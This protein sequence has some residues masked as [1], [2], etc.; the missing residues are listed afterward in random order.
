[1]SQYT[2]F[3]WLIVNGCVR[4]FG[5]GAIV[6]GVVF[7]AW[8]SWLLLHRDATIGVNGVPSNDPWDKATILIAGLVVLVLGILVL[9]AR[10]YRPDLGDSASSI[11]KWNS[12]KSEKN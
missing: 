3:H 8:S 1:M 5:V 9:K 10:R 6:A 2:K 4:V 12:G 11:G 7:T